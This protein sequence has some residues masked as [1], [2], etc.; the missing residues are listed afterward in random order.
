MDRPRRS[1]GLWRRR[2]SAPTIAGMDVPLIVAAWLHTVAFAI[3]WGYYGVLARLVMPSLEGVLDPRDWAV[4][5]VSIE[6]RALPLLGAALVAIVATGIWLLVGDPRY[7]G[8]GSALASPWATLMLVKHVAVVV[9]V[10][11]AVL[12][13]RATRDFAAALDDSAR[14]GAGR[15][16]ARLAEVTTGVGALIA[17]L[18][19]AAQDAA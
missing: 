11:L 10:A 2:A 16:V 9:F 1:V 7:G 6:R 15:R 17:L 4:S 18:T 8:P 3:A 14:R 5:V 13:D 12:V 19:V